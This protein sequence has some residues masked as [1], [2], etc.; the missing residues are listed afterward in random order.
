MSLA[1]DLRVVQLLCSRIC[2]DLAGPVGA[3]SNGLELVR[4]MAGTPDTEAMDLVELSAG[5]MFERLRFFR[6]AFGLAQGAVRTTTEAR[7]LVTPAVIGERC[8]FVW[9]GSEPDAALP[10]GDQGLKLMLNMSLLAGETLPRGGEVSATLTP[11]GGRTTVSLAASGQGARVEDDVRRALSLQSA[12]EEVTPRS[13]PA[14]LAGVI[15]Q[16][17]GGEVAIDESLADRIVLEATVSA[18]G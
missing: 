16:S 18:D 4:E 5:K 1:L 7:N 14:L 11:E 6:V 15:A 9:P 12:A 8:T 17:L 10:V 2:H 3:V 13:A